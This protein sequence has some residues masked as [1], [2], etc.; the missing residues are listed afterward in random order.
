MLVRWIL[1]TYYDSRALVRNIESKDRTRIIKLLVP[2]NSENRI[3]GAANVCELR[4]WAMAPI[5][6]RT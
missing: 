6:M 5:Q 3:R 1:G 2:T 4:S